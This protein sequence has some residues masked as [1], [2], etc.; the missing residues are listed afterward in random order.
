MM[1]NKALS[2]YY[3]LLLGSDMYDDLVVWQCGEF[4]NV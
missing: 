4:H 2:V 1:F 3:Q